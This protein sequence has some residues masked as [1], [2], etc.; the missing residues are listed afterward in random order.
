MRKSSAPGSPV[1]PIATAV[2]CVTGLFVLVMLLSLLVHQAS[3]GNGPVC[4]TVSPND[5]SLFGGPVSVS[6]LAAGTKASAATIDICANHPTAALRVAGLVAAWPYTILWATFLFRLVRVLDFASQPAML[7]S[8]ET[9]ARL[10]G[11][12]WLMTGGGIVASVIASAAKIFIFTRLVHYPGLGWFAPW[13]VDFSVWT[14]IIGLAL[15]S[16]A[17]IMRLGATMREEL[18]VTV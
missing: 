1:E 11:I 12:G 14:L 6:G 16:V 17:R 5:A 18:D 7:Y 8:A 13:Q 3:W 15:L 2:G 4:S 10:R 9:A